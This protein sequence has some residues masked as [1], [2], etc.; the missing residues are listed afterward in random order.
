MRVD[1]FVCLDIRN[2]EYEYERD[3]WEN[4][5]CCSILA[6]LYNMWC[7]YFLVDWDVWYNNIDYW[8]GQ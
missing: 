8:V 4:K 3:G 7:G 2:Y 5:N 1:G 6:V